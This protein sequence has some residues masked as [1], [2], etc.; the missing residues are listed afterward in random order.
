MSSLLHC[1]LKKP[2]FSK[3]VKPWA[4]KFGCLLLLSLSIPVANSAIVY[5][6]EGTSLDFFG[7]IR[8]MYVNEHAYQDIANYDSQDN[9][10]YA[11]AR[12]GIAGRSEISHGLDAIAMAQWDTQSDE[13]GHYGDLGETK[14]MYAGFDAYQYGSLIVG[15]GDT[16]YYTIAGATDIFNI[17]DAQGSDYYIYGDQRPSQIMYSLRALSWD[18]KLSYMLATNELGETPLVAKRGMAASV[19]TKFGDNITFAYGID[20]YKFDFD[21]NQRQAEEF[22]AHQFMADGFSYA[23]ALQRS[24]HHHVSTKKEYGIALSY[25]V[26][27]SGFYG[28]IVLGTTDYDYINHKLYTLD[29][30]LNY[31]LDNGLSMSLGYALKRYEDIN[32]ISQLTVGLSYKVTPTV[33]LF[34]EAQFDLDGQADI[35]YGTYMCDQLNLNENKV[36][37]G[38]EISF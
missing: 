37:V 21:V 1:N 17:I 19:S 29:T 9:G 28:A 22:F 38:A 30:A 3:P 12:I 6:K 36:A 26:L 20:Y 15:R 35:F 31:T 14:Y 18:L 23:G 5:N 8:A 13:Q 2:N 10:I 7:H 34:S 27:G 16:A 32:I 33:K 24:Q 25:G 4:Y 11:Q